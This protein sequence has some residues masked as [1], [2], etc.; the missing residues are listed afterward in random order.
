[1]TTYSINQA[2]EVGQVLLLML[3]RGNL[4]SCRELL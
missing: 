2:G 4:L 1:M 3:L